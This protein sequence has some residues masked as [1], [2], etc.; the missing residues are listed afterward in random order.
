LQKERNKQKQRRKL[1]RKREWVKKHNK[2]KMNVREK[3]R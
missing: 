3:E 2:G 1:E